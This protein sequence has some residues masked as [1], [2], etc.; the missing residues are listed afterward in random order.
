MAPTV[1]YGLGGYDPSKPNNNV[2]AM[3]DADWPQEPLNQAGVLATLNA[4]LGIWSVEDAAN[5][6]HLSPADLV[7]EAEA[8]AAAGDLA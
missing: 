1:T 6:V 5:A 3:N 4:V 7:A 2:V 8:W